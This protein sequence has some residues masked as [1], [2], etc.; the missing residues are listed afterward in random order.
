[1]KYIIIGLAIV[2]VVFIVIFVWSCCKIAAETDE[3]MGMK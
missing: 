2:V 1:M 3:R